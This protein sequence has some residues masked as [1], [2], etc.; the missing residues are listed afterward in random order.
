MVAVSMR[1]K[2]LQQNHDKLLMKLVVWTLMAEWKPKEEIE[3][4]LE[5]II[6][7]IT[8]DSFPKTMKQ[9][10]K[11]IMYMVALMYIDA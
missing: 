5:W 4:R 8:K 1:V 11:N 10:K 9:N 2:E 3:V 6:T 7:K